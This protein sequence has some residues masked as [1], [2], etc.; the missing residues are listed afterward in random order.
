MNVHPNVFDLH[1]SKKKKVHGRMKFAQPWYD[2]QNIVDFTRRC[3]H[4]I[5]WT[6]DRY[7]LTVIG[8]DKHI[9]T[10]NAQLAKKILCQRNLYSLN[11]LFDIQKYY[12]PKRVPPF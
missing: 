4:F 7:Y 3:F 12:R 2:I 11:V 1:E 5:I 6:L 10:T 8:Y 9:T